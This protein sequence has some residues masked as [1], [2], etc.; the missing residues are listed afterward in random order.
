ME[1][2]L[3][4]ISE[5][6]EKKKAKVVSGFRVNYKYVAC[7]CMRLNNKYDVGLAM[8]KMCMVSPY[9]SSLCIC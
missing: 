7:S 5:E 4:I 8:N 9:F 1:N 6:R 3:Q 2:K